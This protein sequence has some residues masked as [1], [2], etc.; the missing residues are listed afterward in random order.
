MLGL[1]DPVTARTG[2]AI[3]PYYPGHVRM[4]TVQHLI[5][6]RANLVLAQPGATDAKAGRDA[7]R[8]SELTFLY[9][10]ADLNDL[11]DTAQVIEIPQVDGKV[12]LVIYLTPNAK[13]DAAIERNGWNVYP[14]DHTC[15]I[16]DMDVVA[17]SGPFVDF[18]NRM[19][20]MVGERTCP[21]T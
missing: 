8:L 10:S 17:G 11:P 15:V 19:S 14:I 18:A 13:V 1:T 12:W 7:Y 6:E 9:P 3:N 4:A 20:R 16:E 21:Q 2:Y 5:D